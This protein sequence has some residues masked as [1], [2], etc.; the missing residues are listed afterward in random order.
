[1]SILI[2][3]AWIVNSESTHH[4]SQKDILIERGIITA[5]DKKITT[6]AK[7]IIEGKNLHVSQGWI[8]LHAQFND[9]GFEFKEDLES[10]AQAAKNGGF[11][12]VV[13]SAENLPVTDN[14]AQIRFIEYQSKGLPTEIKT[15]AT[16]TEGLKG[17]N[18]SELYDLHLSG[19]VGFSDGHHSIENPDLLKRALLYSKT[20][21][22]KVLVYPND[23]RISQN[24]VMHEGT[25]STRLGLKS[26]PSL[27][28]EIRIA[29]DI[30]IAEYC[31]ASIHFTNVSTENAVD[32]IKRAKKRGIQIT[33]DVAIANLIWNDT[34]LAE[35]NSNYKVI[36]PLRS[37]KDRKALIKGVKDGIIDCIVTNHMPQNIEEKQCE[38]DLAGFGQTSIETAFS[39]YQTYLSKYMDIETWI[40]AISERPRNIFDQKI[41]LIEINQKANLTIFDTDVSWIVNSNDL[42][43]KSKNTP[44]IGETLNGRVI[45]TVF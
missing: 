21:N 7:K 32:Q 37:E 11:T 13:V 2:K 6:K 8:D 27:S 28:E 3:N 24:G 10:G 38:F 30:A 1:M 42:K 19:A 29:R 4:L 18:F 17:Q 39:L 20:F 22:G 5:I 43:S 41:G 15:F 36:P 23:I 34:A 12:T 35:F 33:C 9:P 26:N 40:K 31:D 25:I 16:L 44:V 45:D 14:K